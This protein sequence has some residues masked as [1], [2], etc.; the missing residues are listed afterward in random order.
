MDIKTLAKVNKITDDIRNLEIKIVELTKTIESNGYFGDVID[1]SIR[2][3]C[4]KEELITITSYIRGFLADKLATLTSEL[5]TYT[6]T[7]TD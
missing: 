7:K 2:D 3:L 4:T 5:N 6:L 1:K